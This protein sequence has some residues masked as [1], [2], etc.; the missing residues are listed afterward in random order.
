MNK[1]NILLT[2]LPRSGT[3]LMCNLLSGLPNT[4]ALHEPMEV[5]D[6]PKFDRPAGIV[7]HIE[8]FLDESRKSL[9][10]SG[11]AASKQ[12]GGKVPTNPFSER[13]ALF[14]RRK[15][16]TRPGQVSID[17]PLSEGFVLAIKHPSAFTALLED[18]AGHFEVFATV[19]NPLSVLA[20]WNSVE[21]P[22]SDGHAPAAED[23]TPDLKAALSLMPTVTERQVHLLC[24]FME[25]FARILQ[26]DHVIRYEDLVRS[27]GTALTVITPSATQLDEALESRNANKLYDKKRMRELGAALLDLDDDAPL[28]RFYTREDVQAL[29]PK[30]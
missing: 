12:V 17:K 25:R 20:S 13:R 28:W 26:P 18:F 8:E 22:A 7:R 23:L 21:V 30:S 14:G 2:G 16:R 1:S 10:S 6:F 29:S 19:R 3:T 11:I 4:V 9:L 15:E 24:W 27:R 5:T